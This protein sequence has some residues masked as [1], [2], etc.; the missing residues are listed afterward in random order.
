MA[1]MNNYGLNLGDRTSVIGNFDRGQRPSIYFSLS[2]PSLSQAEEGLGRFN[3]D[4]VGFIDH[5]MGQTQPQLQWQFHNFQPNRVEG[6]L[7]I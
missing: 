7:T 4:S 6:S 2:D 1:Y 5:V 3:F